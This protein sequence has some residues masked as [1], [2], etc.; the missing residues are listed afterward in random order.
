[1]LAILLCVATL[2]ALD[3]ANAQPQPATLELSP[4]NGGQQPT[5]SSVNEETP[6]VSNN[7][8]SNT[9]VTSDTS[10]SSTTITING[11]T[12]TVPAN[13]AYQETTKNSNGETS[14]RVE[15]SSSSS[16]SGQNS[17]SVNINVNSR[18]GSDD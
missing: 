2:A 4:A 18:S 1:M 15:H 6:G 13:G 5:N 11:K 8:T 7:T 17:S 10:G 9:S 12:V 14:L 16:G 3:A